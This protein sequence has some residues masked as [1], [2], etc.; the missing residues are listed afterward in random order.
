[1]FLVMLLLATSARADE[2]EDIS[3]ALDTINRFAS[4]ICGKPDL[5]GSSSASELDG[6]VG[7]EANTLVRQLTGLKIEA[8]GRLQSTQY[9][10]LLQKDMLAALKDSA[11]CKVN[12]YDDLKDRILPK[13]GAAD[14]TRL[15]KSIGLRPVE[16]N[17]G[18]AEKSTGYNWQV[19]Y[20]FRLTNPNQT[21]AICDTTVECGKYRKDNDE[22]MEQYQ[23]HRH[24]TY[25][26]AASEEDVPG[27]LYCGGFTDA[28]GSIA[29][30]VTTK[31]C[32][33][34]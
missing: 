3:K 13:K 4:S 16:T 2:L 1:M 34:R 27:L 7:I 14:R 9:Q 11:T 23:S 8:G 10:G 31:N 28:I 17:F 15:E 19:K 32:T 6:K 18:R 30:S 12:L 20:T 26:E 21:G 33:P 24:R 5:R 22:R 25:I 29:I